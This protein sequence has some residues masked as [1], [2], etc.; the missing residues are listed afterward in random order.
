MNTPMIETTLLKQKTEEEASPSVKKH[1]QGMTRLL[2]FLMVETRPNI[3]FATFVAS[4]FAKSPNHQ[5]IEAV[6]TLLQY[7]K[8]SQD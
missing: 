7:L 3:A 1:Y 4:R 6:K 8:R 2:M 5:H